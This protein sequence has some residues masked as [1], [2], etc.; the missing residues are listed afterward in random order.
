M[1]PELTWVLQ[2][3]LDQSNTFIYIVDTELRYLFL[4]RIALDL[5]Y[6]GR[7]LEEVLGKRGRDFFPANDGRT[8]DLDLLEANDRYVLR[9]GFP[10]QVYETLLG[11]VLY[12]QKWP[13]FDDSGRCFA[14][15]GVSFDVTNVVSE[16]VRGEGDDAELMLNMM[17]SSSRM[18]SAMLRMTATLN[19]S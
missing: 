6:A 16:R 10:V 18:I 1:E 17:N 4:N 15:A 11:K 13:L 2:R 5:A 9:T 12:A 19:R 3:A 8:S 7:R 14:V